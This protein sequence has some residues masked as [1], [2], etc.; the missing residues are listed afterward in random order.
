M[1]IF[2]AQVRSFTPGLDAAIGLNEEQ[3]QALVAAY[4]ETYQTS[5]V[6]LANMVLQDDN[7]SQTQRQAASAILQQSQTAFQA[8]SREVFTRPVRLSDMNHRMHPKAPQ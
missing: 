6:A 2:D 4:R 7:A 8:K 5:A 1:W 3:G